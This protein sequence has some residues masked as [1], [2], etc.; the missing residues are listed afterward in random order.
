[1]DPAT[2]LY[3]N[4]SSRPVEL[5]LADGVVV[6]PPRATIERGVRDPI[7]GVLERR[8]VLTRHAL[9]VV[10]APPPETEAV[11]EPRPTARI[12][13]GERARSSGANRGEKRTPSRGGGE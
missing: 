4:A 2:A 5:H 7:C 9:P 13:A 1:M 8:G 11:D 6:L 12:V 10:E 3:R